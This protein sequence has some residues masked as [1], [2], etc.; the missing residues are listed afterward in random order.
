M[1]TIVPDEIISPSGS[2]A[3]LYTAFKKHLGRTV[4]QELLRKWPE[5]AEQP[6]LDRTQN[7]YEVS[8]A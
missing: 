1:N 4:G 5:R 7:I 3:A 2:R 8:A 6:L